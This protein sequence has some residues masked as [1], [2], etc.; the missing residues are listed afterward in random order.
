MP[1]PMVVPTTM[2][3]ASISP[4]LRGSSPAAGEDT[5]TAFSLTWCTVVLP[6]SAYG[7]VVYRIAGGKARAGSERNGVARDVLVHGMTR[8]DVVILLGVL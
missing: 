8:A 6:L 2:Q 5:G 7:C 1:T 4:S 3:L